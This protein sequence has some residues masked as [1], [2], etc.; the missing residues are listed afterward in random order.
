MKTQCCSRP[1]CP[2]GEF[3]HSTKN[4]S[5]T[6]GSYGR[7]FHACFLDEAPS[8]T[9]EQYERAA[10]MLEDSAAG[11]VSYSPETLDIMRAVVREF[12][13]TTR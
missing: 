2:N 13:R 7:R 8:T 12:E 3:G 1:D 10:Q 5:T 9:R 4:Y 6:G 11:D